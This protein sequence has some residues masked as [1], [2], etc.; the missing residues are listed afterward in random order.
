M[1]EGRRSR[2]RGM[3]HR[4]PLAAY[5]GL[6]FGISWTGVLIAMGPGPIPAPPDLAQ[7]RFVFVYLAML[8]GPPTAGI[9]MTAAVGGTGV[10]V[11]VGAGGCRV[12]DVV[13]QG[14]RQAVAFVSW[15]RAVENGSQESIGTRKVPS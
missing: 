5:F 8:A 1:R 10:G 9:L 6:A 15:K 7:Q 14:R 13:L 2:V 3:V 11:V 12:G 4:H